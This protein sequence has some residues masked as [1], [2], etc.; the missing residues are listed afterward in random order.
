MKFLYGKQNMRSMSRAQEASFLLTNGLGGYASV[1]SAFSVPRCDQGILVAA[2]KAPNERITMVHRMSET[3]KIGNTEVFLS[4]QEFADSTAPEDG[5]RNLSCF[6]YEYT[7]C[8]TYHVSGV[9]VERRCAMAYGKNTVAVLYTI[10]NQSEFPCT[11]RI[12]PFLKFTPK[13]EAIEEEKELIYDNGRVTSGTHTLYIHT[14]AAL[15][16]CAPRW[17]MLS[18]PEDEKDGRPEK[19]LAGSC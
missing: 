10:E 4:T 5:Y 7:P 11:L 9:Q 18:Y 2:V 16:E 3:L 6:S 17:Q 1:T 12:E 15:E 14:D 19:G 13:E 8:W